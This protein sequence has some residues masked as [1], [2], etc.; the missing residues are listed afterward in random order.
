MASEHDRLLYRDG[1]AH[2][3][4]R[5]AHQPRRA[6]EAAVVSRL[7]DAAPFG[8][9]QLRLLAAACA[10]WF[11]FGLM[12]TADALALSRLQAHY[13]LDDP[14]SGQLVS[15]IALGLLVASPLAGLLSDAAGRKKII[16]AGALIA[17]LSG[18]LKAWSP[19]IQWQLLAH[20]LEGVGCALVWVPFPI[21][22]GEQLPTRLRGPLTILF[23]AGWPL[24]SIAATGLGEWL[25]PVS[26]PLFFI[27]TS[28]PMAL[29]AVAFACVAY[30]SARFHVDAGNRKTA[31]DTI[32]DIYTRNGCAAP[33][34][35]EVGD[36][37][38]GRPRRIHGNNGDNG[39][40][41]GGGGGDGTGGGP[42]NGGK[43][44][45]TGI[46]L[47]DAADDPAAAA[48]ANPCTAHARA[49]CG[50]TERVTMYATWLAIAAASWGATF[51]MPTY[52]E[53][54][55][56]LDLLPPET[57]DADLQDLPPGTE[58]IEHANPTTPYRL[59]IF[60]SLCDLC[61]IALA[62]RLVDRLGRTRVMQAAFFASSGALLG[63]TLVKGEAPV[64][65]FSG[66]MQFAQAIVWTVL[67][68]FTLEAFPAS[69]RATAMGLANTVARVGAIASP[70][71]C[72]YLMQDDVHAAMW[73][74]SALYFVGF[75]LTF[76]LAPCQTGKGLA[77]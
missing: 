47:D 46:A 19:T 52:I 30:E 42:I 56:K 4:I 9:V 53:R 43:G 39:G 76:S 24:G 45:G 5:A 37:R 77:F 20:A 2:L 71:V 63:L 28:V 72:G 17:L 64:L 38:D 54:R 23:C 32:I 61:G 13:Q 69:V 66:S 73:L 41:G 21:L 34:D 68:L 18:L 14:E 16:S 31:R 58:I 57:Q 59:V 50:S 36:W 8:R 29:A 51:W 6:S 33:T 65:L 10:L 7:M 3:D 48:H 15:A 35:F 62:A 11:C 67:S 49:L 75:L 40:E 27:A 44:K 12:F 1:A 74:C 25:L 55:V 70:M 60:Q 26:W 22:I